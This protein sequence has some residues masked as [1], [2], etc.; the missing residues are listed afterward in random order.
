ML[1]ISLG[2]YRILSSGFLA[3]AIDISA[4]CSLL[5]ITFTQKLMAAH[6]TKPQSSRLKDASIEVPSFCSCF[7]SLTPNPQLLLHSLDCGWL[8]DCHRLWKF[9]KHFLFV[10][11]LGSGPEFGSYFFYCLPSFPL[12]NSLLPPHSQPLPASCLLAVST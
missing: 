2:T 8:F 12:N 11:P 10:S 5:A 7:P 6:M 3:G 4:L 9:D 1:A